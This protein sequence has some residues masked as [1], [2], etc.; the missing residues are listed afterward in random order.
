MARSR[1]PSHSLLQPV[2]AIENASAAKRKTSRNMKRGADDSIV[3]QLYRSQADS[4]RS[5]ETS[6]CG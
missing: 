3:F 5:A 1:A 6:Y 4:A 2:S